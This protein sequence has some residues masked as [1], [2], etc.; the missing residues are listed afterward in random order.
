MEDPV[1]GVESQNMAAESRTERVAAIAAL[2]EPNRRRLYDYVAG[3]DGPV[4]RDEA[5]EAT[6]LARATA[7]FH[8][9][10][11]VTDG[12]L[13]VVYE[14]RSGR[15][16]PGAGRPAKLYRRSPEE[17]AVSLPDR[18]YQ[19]VG[20]LLADA[21][22]EAET[23]GGSPRA[24]LDR[25]A[26]RAGVAYG[27]AARSSGTGPVPIAEALAGLGFEPRAENDSI[28]LAN[29]P[30]HALA[31]RHTAMV[32]GMNLRLLDGVLEGLSATGLAARLDP[33][34]GR[35]CVRIGPGAPG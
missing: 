30:F 13:D 32:C 20:N 2:D 35:C 26:H 8:L 1:K 17:I 22:A 24:A 12:L 4:G 23:G 11:M 5:A 21:I 16:G 14:R 6:G 31:Q 10:R 29:C 34:P 18:R 15:T 25:H 33:G 27:L 3:Q 9:D 28:V 7:A 19:L